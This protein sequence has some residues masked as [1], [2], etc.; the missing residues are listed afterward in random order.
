MEPSTLPTLIDIEEAS[1]G[2]NDGLQ[3]FRAPGSME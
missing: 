3:G 1:Q 2:T